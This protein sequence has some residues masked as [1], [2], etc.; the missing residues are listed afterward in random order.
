MP[1]PFTGGTG[2]LDETWSK[3]PRR[4]DGNRELS[5]LEEC[6]LNLGILDE[7]GIRRK[8]VRSLP[9]RIED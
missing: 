9:R 4:R 5:A 1:E 3:Q 7:R 2:R 8:V 6:R